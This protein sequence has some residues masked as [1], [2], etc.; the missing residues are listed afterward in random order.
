MA[1]N[2][3]NAETERLAERVVTLTGETK[4]AAVTQA[5]RGRLERAP[6]RRRLADELDAIARHAASLP[7]LDPRSADEILGYDADGLPR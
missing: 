1:L 2:I 3:R 4:T 6:V 5:L 7:L